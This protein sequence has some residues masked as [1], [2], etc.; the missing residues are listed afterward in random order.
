[1]V[2]KVAVQVELRLGVDGAVHRLRAQGVEDWVGSRP[3]GT[4]GGRWRRHDAEVGSSVVKRRGGGTR[5]VVDAKR[6]GRSR[7]DS[8]ERVAW[9]YAS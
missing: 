4:G 1:M 3:A 9:R 6:L 2:T 8:R 5:R 7:E